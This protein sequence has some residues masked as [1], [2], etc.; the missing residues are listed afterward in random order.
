MNRKQLLALVLIGL[1]V[2]VMIMNRSGLT[3]NLFGWEIHTIESFAILACL[4]LGVLI[5]ILLK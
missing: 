4:A 2:I 3:L 1:L 5:G